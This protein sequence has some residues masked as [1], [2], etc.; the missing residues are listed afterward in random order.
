MRKKLLPVKRFEY[1]RHHST[2]SSVVKVMDDIIRSIDDGKVVPQ[3]LLDLSAAFDTVDHDNLLE[4]LQN[5]FL[6]ND[7]PLSWFH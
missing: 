2:E 4:I 6:I 1:R 3:V 5:R 7:I